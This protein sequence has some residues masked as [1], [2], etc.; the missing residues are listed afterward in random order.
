MVQIPSNNRL[1]SSLRV[2]GYA[3]FMLLLL[4]YGFLLISAQF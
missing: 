2:L 4:D 3:F 1:I